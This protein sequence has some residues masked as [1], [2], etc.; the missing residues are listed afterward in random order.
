MNIRN[1]SVTPS[2]LMLLVDDLEAKR[3]VYD[4]KPGEYELKKYLPSVPSPPTPT[5]GY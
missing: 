3:F 5:H 4:F 2:G 1:A